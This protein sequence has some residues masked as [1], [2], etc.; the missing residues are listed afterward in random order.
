MFD[1]KDMI[2]LLM[3]R[4]SAIKWNDEDKIFDTQ[5]RIRNKMFEQ[6]HTRI[7]GIFLTFRNDKDVKLA[8]QLYRDS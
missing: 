3:E 1:N 2:E 4:G 5:E 7:S 6:Y 8:Q